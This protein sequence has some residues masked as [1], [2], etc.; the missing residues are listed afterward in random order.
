MMEGFIY[1][2]SQYTM[3]EL[4]IIIITFINIYVQEGN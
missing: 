2:V 4:S 3:I 1:V